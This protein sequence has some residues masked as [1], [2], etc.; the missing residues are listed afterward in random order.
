MSKFPMY[1]SVT[2]QRVYSSPHVSP[3]EFKIHVE[4]QYIPVFRKLFEQ[5]NELEFEN[6]LRAHLPYI[7]YHY[8]HNNHELDHRTKKIYAI[9]HEFG[10][11]ETKSFIE[12]L[13][14]FR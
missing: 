4:R 13:P 7:P 12:N 10:D 1:V 11:Q 14:Y 2:D 3:W 5:M 6:F 8:D 9:I